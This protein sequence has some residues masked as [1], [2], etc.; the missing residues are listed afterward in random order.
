VATKDLQQAFNA[1]LNKELY[2]AYLYLSMAAWFEAENLPGMAGWMRAQA[3]EEYQ[4][5]MKFW[6]H[7]SDRGGRVE[8]L[9]IGQPPSQFKGAT[10][11]FEQALEHERQVSGQ[12]NKLYETAEKEHDHAAEVFLQWFIAEQVEEEKTAQQMVDQLKMANGSPAALLM[13]DREFGSR[14]SAAQ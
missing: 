6:E 5:A 1:H 3:S 11:A 10:D 9:A 4:H 8:L 14:N 13:L 2:A 12:I 7:L